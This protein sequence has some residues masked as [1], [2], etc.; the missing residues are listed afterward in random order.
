MRIFVS[1]R[2]SDTQHPAG[3]LAEHLEARFG[4]RSVFM[5]V[6]RIEPGQDFAQTVVDE[7]GACDVL[8][9]MIGE[10]WLDEQGRRR[11]HDPHDIV[12]LE[13]TTALERDIRLIPV[14]VDGAPPPRVDDLPSALAPLARRHA[15]RLEH[16][17]FRADVAELATALERRPEASRGPRVELLGE[18]PGRVGSVAGLAFSADGGQVAACGAEGVQ[19][20]DVSSGAAVSSP[21]RAFGAVRG[22]AFSPDGR[23]LAV[24]GTTAKVSL[25]DRGTGSSHALKG[26]PLA[27]GPLAFSPDGKHLAAGGSPWSSSGG[28]VARLVKPVASRDLNG[29]V[30]LWDTGTRAQRY[31]FE[32]SGGRVLR[33]VFSPTGEYLVAACDDGSLHVVTWTTSG[34]R[35]SADG[36]LLGGPPT[37]R[38]HAGEVPGLAFIGPRLVSGGVDGT[39]RYWDPLESTCLHVAQGHAGPVGSVAVSADGG[40]VVSAGAD[41]T[42]RLWDPSTGQPL[43]VLDGRTDQAPVAELSPY[44]PLLATGG[45]DGVVRMWRWSAG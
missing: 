25:W 29:A 30:R 41:G 38:G 18:L 43:R 36:R 39:L 35:R 37:L 40:L 6:D 11:L 1:Y 16:T 34:M 27:E 10:H 33:L 26:S 20:W 3:R 15:V 32:S 5:D 13:I 9:V 42:V 45:A 23:F 7:V 8:L 24:C 17:T 14:L 22:V 2:R 4:P 19:I 44:A 28:A 31:Q 21:G 12:A